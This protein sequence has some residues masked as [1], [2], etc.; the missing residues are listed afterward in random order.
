MPQ[1]AFLN[2]KMHKMCF[3]PRTPLAELTALSDPIP[4][5]RAYFSGKGSRAYINGDRRGRRDSALKIH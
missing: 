5:L 4:G 1:D 3:R 2:R